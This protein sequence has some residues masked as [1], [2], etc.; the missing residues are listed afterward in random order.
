MTPMNVDTEA[1]YEI[2][3]SDHGIGGFGKISKQRDTFLERLV[4]VKGLH[5][6]TDEKLRERF[7]REAKTLAKMSH[8]N[9][10]AIYDVKLKNEEILIYFEFI[11]GIN[12]REII[13]SGKDISLKEA[14]TWFSQVASSIEHAASHKIVHRDIKPDNIIISKNG[15]AYLVDFGIALNPDDANRITEKGYAIGTPAYMSPEQREGK[16]LDE[17]SDIYSLGITLYETLSGRLP[18]GGGYES[19]SDANEAIPPSIDDLIKDCLVVDK[20]RRLSSAK[21]FN[22]R[23]RSAFRT[24][25]PLS[26]LLMDARLHELHA[27]L[28]SMSAEEFSAKP[29]G[30][31]LL[32]ITRIKDLIRT[33]KLQGPTA[34]MIALLVRLAIEEPAEQ[35]R[36]IVEAAYEWGYEKQYGERWKGNEP[37]RDALIDAAKSA[38]NI[39]Q[40]VLSNSLIA[41]LEKVGLDGKDGWYYHDLRINIQSLLANPHCS[42]SIAAEKLASLYDQVNQISH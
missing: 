32:I 18:V 7:T 24:D 25:V 39:A 17:A 12:L 23:L 3:D 15:S 21:E 40:P 41:F 30:Q 34:D 10:P 13:K 11:D 2:L 42:E 19:L 31:R 22:K 16:E 38:S 5:K 6:V 1:R 27:A 4:A 33:D 8:P 37:I 36:P 35:Y 29:I 14:V 20:L 28:Q 9:I 26:Q